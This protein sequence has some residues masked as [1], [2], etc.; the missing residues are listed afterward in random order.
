MPR[1]LKEYA[2]YQGDEF[3]MLGTLEECAEE[4]GV[5]PATIRYWTMPTH[6]KRAELKKGA[7]STWKVAIRVE[8]DDE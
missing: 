3:L 5:L 1:A 6:H 4:M 7:D 8:D 2:V